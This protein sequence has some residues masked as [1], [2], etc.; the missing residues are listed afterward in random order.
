M[1]VNQNYKRT[2]RRTAYITEYNKIF[3]ECKIH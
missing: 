3:S 1:E 2:E